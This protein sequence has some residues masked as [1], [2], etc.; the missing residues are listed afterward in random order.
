MTNFDETIIR[1]GTGSAKWDSLESLYGEK[2]ILPMWVADMDFK[3]AKPIRDALHKVIDHQILGYSLPSESLIN[4]ITSWQKKRHD[5]N[6][7]PENILFSP[8]VVGSIAICVQAFTQSK[9]AIMIHD[10]VY[11]PFTAIVEANNRTLVRSS[12]VKE[13]GRYTMNFSD[14]E[15]KIIKYDVKL[16]ILSNPHNPGGRVWSKN[17]LEKLADLCVKYHVL[18]V[19]DEIHSDLIFEGAACTSPVTLKDE[20]KRW[21]ITLHSATKTFNIAGVKCSFIFV[22]DES[23]KERII[24]TQEQTHQETI[25]TFGYMATEAAFSSSGN[26]L[27]ELLIYLEENRQLVID[28]FD[29]ELPNVDYMIPEATYLFWFNASSCREENNELKQ[30]FSTIGKIALNEGASFGPEGEGWLR[31]NFASPRSMVQDG[32]KR[33]KKTFHETQQFN[34]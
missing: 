18:L 11:H 30:T 31:L 21:I 19:S 6:L 28:F 32:L 13:N 10:P 12:L 24:Q 3:N 33:I 27:D 29:N 16:F 7:L 25:S 4:S 8:G 15:D 34:G 20:Y 2:D 26:W 14:I 17:E 5:M 1:R 22:F 9:E 23:L